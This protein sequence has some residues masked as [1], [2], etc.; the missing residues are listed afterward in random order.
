M[1]IRLCTRP[2]RV[3]GTIMERFETFAS[4]ERKIVEINGIRNCARGSKKGVCVK[5]EHLLRKT[6]LKSLN[7]CISASRHDNM[8]L[9]GKESY[10]F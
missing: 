9:F 10:I 1:M 3:N 5:I 6:D 2:I 4:G 7:I 8:A